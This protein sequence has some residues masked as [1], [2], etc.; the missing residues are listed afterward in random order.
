MS[1]M[2]DATML[3]IERACAKAGIHDE[4]EIM[5]FAE[6]FYTDKASEAERRAVADELANVTRADIGRGPL[7]E[8]Q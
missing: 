7:P 6:R 2:A 5:D 8:S 1:C 3:A 4:A